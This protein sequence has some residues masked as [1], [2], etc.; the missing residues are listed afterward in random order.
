[1]E[2]L[3][4]YPKEFKQDEKNPT[5]YTFEE[6]LDICQALTYTK[7]RVDVNEIPLEKRVLSISSSTNI[8][9]TILNL[10]EQFGAECEIIPTMF[11][12]GRGLKD[13]KL[14]IYKAKT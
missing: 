11:P 12:D 8:Y 3:N 1:M 4:E 9:G 13:L 10:A 6:Y 5:S 7:I 14:N 2:L